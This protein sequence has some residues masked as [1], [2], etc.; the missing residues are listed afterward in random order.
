MTYFNGL[1]PEGAV[2]TAAARQLGISEANTYGLL[3]GLG[4]DVAGAIQLLPEGV[5]EPISPTEDQPVPL[6][7]EDLLRLIDSLPFRPMLVGE[8]G[9]RLSLAGAQVKAAVVLVGGR[10]AKPCPGQPTTHILKPAASRFA[11]LVETFLQDLSEKVVQRA[12]HCV[13][14]LPG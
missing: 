4:G 8:K 10:I 14:S 5:P 13:G 9:L 3:A 1:L 6:E 12:R 7:D 11:G 2:R